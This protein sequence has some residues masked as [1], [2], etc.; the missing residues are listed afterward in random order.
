[1]AV[2]V[3][4]G[5][6][7]R[8]SAREQIQEAI[9]GAEKAAEEKDVGYL[10]DLVSRQYSDA[11]GNDRA[12]L[13]GVLR[14]QFLRTPSIHLLIRVPAIHI[15]GP[16]RAEATVVAAMAST[17]IALPQQLAG[18]GADIYRFELVFARE[19]DDRWRVRSASWSPAA[20]GDLL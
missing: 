4:P 9:A 20:P 14:L 5:C 1:V 7:G 19:D 2:A 8:K 16:A 10:G 11:S 12:A 3:A 15:A 18:L 6:R 13:L 17:P